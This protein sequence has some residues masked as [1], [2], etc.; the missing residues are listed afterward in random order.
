MVEDLLK[1]KFIHNE[2]TQNMK[3]ILTTLAFLLVITMYSQTGCYTFP[4]SARSSVGVLKLG[5]GIMPFMMQDNDQLPIRMFMMEME[6]KTW[7]GG[8]QLD[9]RSGKT[10]LSKTFPYAPSISMDSRL[11]GYH[12]MNDNVSIGGYGQINS[13]SMWVDGCALG[14]LLRYSQDFKNVGMFG[15]VQLPF[16]SM[17]RRPPSTVANGMEHQKLYWFGIPE[18][19]GQDDFHKTRPSEYRFTVG[20]YIRINSRIYPY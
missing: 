1:V 15:Q 18:N 8:V 2:K 3:T 9:A 5:A 7:G 16:F 12:N 4:S 11:Y 19:F 17:Q 13:T 10:Y 14:G 6:Y 20:V